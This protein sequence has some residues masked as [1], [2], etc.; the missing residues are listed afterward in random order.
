M[1]RFIAFVLVLMLSI[2]FE[3]VLAEGDLEVQ[4]IGGGGNITAIK[5]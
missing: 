3:A 1:K 2:G 5:P 4:V